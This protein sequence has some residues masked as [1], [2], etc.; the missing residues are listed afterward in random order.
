[1]KYQVS[2]KREIS[3]F[4]EIEAESEE[5]ALSKYINGDYDTKI[6]EITD[7]SDIESPSVEPIARTKNIEFRKGVSL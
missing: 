4:V 6:E 1:M 3:V 5:E 7:C 2:V